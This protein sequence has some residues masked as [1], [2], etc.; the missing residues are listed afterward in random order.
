MWSLELHDYEWQAFRI[1]KDGIGTAL[2]PVLF[3]ADFVPH[4][5][6]WIAEVFHHPVCEVLAHPFLGCEQ[7]PAQAHVVPNV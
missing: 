1:V 4:A 5:C 7:N 2:L 3:E 6:E